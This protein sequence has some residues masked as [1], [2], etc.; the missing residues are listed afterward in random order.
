[1]QFS[2]TMVF[3]GS[4]G[5]M[6]MVISANFIFLEFLKHLGL[7]PGSKKIITVWDVTVVSTLAQSYVNKAATGVGAVAELAAE[8]KAEK[9]DNLSSDHIFAAN[10]Y[11]EFGCLQLFIFG[12]PEKAWTYIG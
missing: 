9:Y 3:H 6:G 7:C 2:C 10:S 8:R 4:T 1:M 12:V 5:L 11:G